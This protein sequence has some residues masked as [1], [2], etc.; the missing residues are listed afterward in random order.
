MAMAVRFVCSNCKREVVAWDEGR[1]YYID[2]T[3]TKH[4]AYHPDPERDRCTGVDSPH[5]CLACGNDF[6]LDAENQ[7]KKCPT[8]GTAEIADTY[9]LQGL[10]CPYCKTGE[11]KLD[12]DFQCVS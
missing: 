3:G 4:Y 2:A 10:K 11:F 6:L 8:C 12:P 7:I 5:I 1:P 9:R